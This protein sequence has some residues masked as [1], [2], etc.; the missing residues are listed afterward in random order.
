[1]DRSVK[2]ANTYCKDCLKNQ[3]TCEKDPLECR[4]MIDAKLYFKLYDRVDS[5]FYRM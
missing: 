5:K 4:K 1:M 2:K 3:T